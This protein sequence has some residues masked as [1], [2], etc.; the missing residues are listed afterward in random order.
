MK[1][2]KE[3]KKELQKYDYKIKENGRY[4]DLYFDDFRDTKIWEQICDS[5]DVETDVD[6]ITIAYIGIYSK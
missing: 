4:L 6:K 2:T 5:V 3:Q 1:I